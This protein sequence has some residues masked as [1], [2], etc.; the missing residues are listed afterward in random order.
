MI[1]DISLNYPNLGSSSTEVGVRRIKARLK[2]GLRLDANKALILGSKLGLG[3]KGVDLSSIRFRKFRLDQT[4][5]GG[6]ESNFFWLRLL[7]LIRKKLEL[8]SGSHLN[9]LA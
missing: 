7:S 3:S 8:G 6:T 5:R 1:F 4:Y 2:L 9:A